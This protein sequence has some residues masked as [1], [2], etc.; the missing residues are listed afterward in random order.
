MGDPRRALDVANIEL[1]KSIMNIHNAVV[2]Y[3]LIGLNAGRIKKGR[4]FFGLVQQQQVELIAIGLSKIFEQEKGYRL[5]SIPSILR[6]IEKNAIFPTDPD[7]VEQYLGPWKTGNGDHWIDDLKRMS[8]DHY[9]RHQTDLRRLQEARN[10]VF[11]HA[12]AGSPRKDLPSVAT[13]QELLAL[14]FGFHDFINSAF[15]NTHSHPILTDTR[16]QVSLR[17]VLAA[18]GVAD[19][20][21]RWPD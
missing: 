9:A 15:I 3:S 16:I 14:A 11:A 21:I 2:V 10:T 13:F 12:Q 7:V 5:N 8:A 1:S 20:T 6:F 18:V 17:N 19:V 4:T